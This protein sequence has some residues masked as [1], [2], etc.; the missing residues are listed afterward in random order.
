M[1]NDGINDLV[2]VEGYGKIKCNYQQA[3]GSVIKKKLVN[4]PNT[5]GSY[6]NYFCGIVDM[7]NDGLLDIVTR[8]DLLD[9]RLIVFMNQGTAE[10]PLFKDGKYRFLTVNGEQMIHHATLSSFTLGDINND[11]FKDLIFSEAATA[12]LENPGSWNVIVKVYEKIF[13]YELK[14]MKSD[15]DFVEPIIFSE[16]TDSTITSPLFYDHIYTPD[17]MFTDLNNDGFND[18]LSAQYGAPSGEA[19]PYNGGQDHVFIRYA[20]P[21]NVSNSQ[22][23]LLKFKQLNKFNYSHNK[24]TFTKKLTNQYIELYSISGK[25]FKINSRDNRVYTISSAIGKGQYFIKA[26]NQILKFTKN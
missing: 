7:N 5:S 26:D 18:M 9:N 2:W 20:K 8:F 4:A 21:L 15:T 16:I 10:E 6:K 17:F 13:Y 19:Y 23:H 12:E 24:I 1:N 22:S 25:R 14:D 11:G 3:D